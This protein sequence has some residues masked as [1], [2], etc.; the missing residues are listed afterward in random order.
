[1]HMERV[2]TPFL[3]IAIQTV[4]YNYRDQLSHLSEGR[5]LD[6]LKEMADEI[7]RRAEKFQTIARHHIH[8]A[9]ADNL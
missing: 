2:D 5:D 4:L 3:E 8:E 9:E 6:L 1:M 7:S